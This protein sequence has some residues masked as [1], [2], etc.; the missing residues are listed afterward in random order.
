MEQQIFSSE[1]AKSLGIGVSTLR[2]YAA[3]LEARGYG[4]ERGTNN[5]RIFRQDDLTLLSQMIEKITKDGITVEQAAE[6]A[7]E[8]TPHKSKVVATQSQDLSQFI[9]QIKGLELQQASLTEMNEA[10]VKQVE[11]LAEKIE[12]R[13]RDQQLFQRLEDSR[14]KKKRKGIAFLRPLTLMAGKK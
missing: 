12:E 5:G 2:K 13:E 4:F 3:I 10:L 1:A 14:N 6:E 11:R 8:A 7:S 9:E